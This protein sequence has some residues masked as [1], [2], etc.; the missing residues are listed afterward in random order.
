MSNLILVRGLP[1]SGKST[2]A[3]LLQEGGGCITSADDY[4][5]APTGEYNFNPSLLPQAHAQ[6]QE[7]TRKHLWEGDVI[8]ANTF[9][10]RWEI[11][12][13]IQIASEANARLTVVDLFDGG[14]ADAELAQRNIHGVPVAGISAMRARW[15]HDWAKGNPIAPWL[16]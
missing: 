6:C 7:E 14:L 3:K 13:Y 2:L 9:S 5:T 1:G 15:E 16:R 4:F 8:V 11:Q 12:P 10:Q